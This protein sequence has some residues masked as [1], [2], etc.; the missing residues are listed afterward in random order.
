MQP[1]KRRE[2]TPHL[3]LCW[4][5]SDLTTRSNCEFNFFFSFQEILRV[6]DDD[7]FL[8]VY[9]ETRMIGIYAS[10]RKLSKVIAFTRV[11]EKL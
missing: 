2:I 10:L 5:N 11:S 9:L 1:A 7:N 8:S 3:S 4:K 6:Y